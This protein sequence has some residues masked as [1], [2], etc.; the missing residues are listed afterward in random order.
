MD[1]VKAL[2]MVIDLSDPL[3]SQH[4]K[5]MHELGNKIDKTTDEILSYLYYWECISSHFAIEHPRGPDEPHIFFQ[6]PIESWHFLLVDTPPEQPLSSSNCYWHE[7]IQY[8]GVLAQQIV[9]NFL[10]QFQIRERIEQVFRKELLPTLVIDF[11]Q[12]ANSINNESNLINTAL[13]YFHYVRKI[14]FNFLDY[15]LCLKQIGW[16]LNKFVLRTACLQILRIWLVGYYKYIHKDYETTVNHMQ[17]MIRLIASHKLDNYTSISALAKHGLILQRLAQAHAN[18]SNKPDTALGFF[19]LAIYGYSDN[20]Q[21]YDIK[22]TILLTADEQ[23]FLY[24]QNTILKITPCKKEILLSTISPPQPNENNIANI[25]NNLYYL[26]I[27][28]PSFK[29]LHPPIQ[30]NDIRPVSI[31]NPTISQYKPNNNNNNDR[32]AESD[33]PVLLVNDH[34]HHNKGGN[35]GPVLAVNTTSALAVNTTAASYFPLTLL[36]PG[37]T[38]GL[39][40]ERVA[41]PTV[42]LDPIIEAVEIE[43]LGIAAMVRTL[44]GVDEKKGEVIGDSRL[45]P[46]EIN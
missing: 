44:P 14:G 12:E 26:G 7:I 6:S 41:T 34:I 36:R 46:I 4:A 2:S 45:L 40:A 33:V 30:K 18:K 19:N 42:T 11:E 20:E 24:K 15:Q 10:V 22:A 13:R 27:C 32:P 17:A 29:F 25:I 37:E 31:I 21:E 9:S 43:E 28:T 5:R 8:T 23:D 1:Y 3:T 16:T 39:Q 38:L 35:S